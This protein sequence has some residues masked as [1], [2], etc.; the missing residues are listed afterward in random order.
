MNS[1]LGSLSLIFILAMS[2]AAQTPRYIA[3]TIDDLPV[4]SLQGAITMQRRITKNILKHIRKAEVPAIGFVNERKLFQDGKRD[5]DQIDLLRMWLNGGLELGNQRRERGLRH[6]GLDR[7]A[8]AFV[9]RGDRRLAHAREH[10][11]D[12][13]EP[14]GGDVDLEH[15]A[16][17]RVEHR[18]E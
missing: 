17:S 2:L 8:A 10:G 6:G 9:K 1:K 3:V 18:A 13:L 16:A 4:V 12:R 15:H 11:D 14:V 5:E 7:I